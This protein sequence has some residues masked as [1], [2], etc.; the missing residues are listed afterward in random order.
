MKCIAN[1]ANNSIAGSLKQ[2]WTN[3]EI[4]I[5]HTI[6]IF[7]IGVSLFMAKEAIN[8]MGMS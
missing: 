3:E 1:N 2:V 5:K 8:D 7:S 6:I 4:G